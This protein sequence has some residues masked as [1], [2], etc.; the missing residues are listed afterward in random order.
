[1]AGFWQVR[2]GEGSSRRRKTIPHLRKAHLPA[3]SNFKG[4]IPRMDSWRHILLSILMKILFHHFSRALLSVHKALSTYRRYLSFQSSFFLLLFT[5]KQ[6]STHDNKQ[7]RGEMAE[8][9]H[10][11]RINCWKWTRTRTCSHTG[12][13]GRSKYCNLISEVEEVWRGPYRSWSS[14]HTARK[15]C[16]YYY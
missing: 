12:M 3:C 11:E 5:C 1:M 2:E 15:W 7:V 13:K 9:H 4:E 6:V 8:K 14:S 16:C 10:N